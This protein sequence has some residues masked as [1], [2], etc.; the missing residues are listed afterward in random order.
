MIVSGSAQVVAE[1]WAVMRLELWFV[2]SGCFKRV[3]AVS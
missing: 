3:L 1:G 2:H